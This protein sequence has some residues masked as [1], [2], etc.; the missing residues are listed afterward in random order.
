MALPFRLCRWAVY[1]RA[2]QPHWVDRIIQIRSLSPKGVTPGSGPLISLLGL[3]RRGTYCRL[4]LKR[5]DS[6]SLDR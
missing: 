2:T 4:F 1:R 6:Q 5:Q 3:D